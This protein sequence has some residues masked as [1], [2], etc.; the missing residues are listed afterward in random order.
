MLLA[1]KDL[2]YY[3]ELNG[4]TEGNLLVKIDSLDLQGANLRSADLQG[5]NLQGAN[6]RSA[7]LRSANLR[8]ANLRGANLQGADLRSADL[9]G[10]NLRSANL[11]SAV[12]NNAQI[13]TVQSGRYVINIVPVLKVIQIGCK[14]YT[15]EEWMGFDDKAIDSL[16]RGGA[17]CWWKT[18]K[19]I[20]A[21]IL[22]S[23]C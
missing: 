22:E 14:R 21:K 16:D 11:R 2:K 12:G 1:L 15:I 7:Y 9:Q 17:L 20:L 5:A 6:L 3:A 13:K 18:W 23:T 10:A 4:I 8:N 19:P